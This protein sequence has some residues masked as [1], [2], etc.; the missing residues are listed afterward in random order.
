[1]RD[2]RTSAVPFLLVP[3]LLLAASACSSGSGRDARPDGPASPSS[4]FAGKAPL[5]LAQLTRA[6]VTDDDVPGW[7]VQPTDSDDGV[8][9]TAPEEFDPDDL[10]AQ[11][12]STGQ[13]ALIADKAACQPIADVVGSQ[14][15]IHRMAS[16][17]ATFAPTS[18]ASGVPEEVDRMTIASHAPGDAQ[19][20]MTALK[21]ALA[22]CTSFTGSDG[23][24]GRVPFTVTR[25]QTVAVGDE[26]V[27][28]VM[29]DT[30]DK[31]TG[32]ALV[33]VV[34]TGDT[35]TSYLSTRA[36][37]GAGTVPL[38]IARKEDQKLRKAL[39]GRK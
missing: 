4:V 24:G 26:A 10:L 35:V 18:A 22:R 23:A 27:S 8:E 3:V 36:S 29:D 20:V 31:K 7:V 11:D 2:V 16:V 37:G 25:A 28:Y 19:R 34:R 9:T 17:G 30:S 1:M 5:T 15:R 38:E 6:L 32:A 14:P 21:G 13:A 33:T 39:A 12:D